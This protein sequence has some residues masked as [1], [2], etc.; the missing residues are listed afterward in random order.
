MPENQKEKNEGAVEEDQKERGYYY[1]DAH[2]YEQYEPEAEDNDAESEGRGNATS[3]RCED[4][5]PG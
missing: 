3:E 1:D 4:A 2:G 5:P